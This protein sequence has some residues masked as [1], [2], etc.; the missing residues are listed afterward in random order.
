MSRKI[1][2]GLSCVL[3]PGSHN[4][5]L[6]KLA[7]Y[8]SITVTIASPMTI[9]LRALDSRFLRQSFHSRHFFWG[10]ILDSLKFPFLSVLTEKE[11]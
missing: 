3:F 2:G 10:N 7:Y 1:S 6:W 5:T 4:D 9:E 8:K 11:L